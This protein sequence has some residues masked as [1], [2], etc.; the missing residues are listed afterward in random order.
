MNSRK[1]CII[2][3]VS[4]KN[5]INK[6]I[7][8]LNIPDGYELEKRYIVNKKN[9]AKAYNEMMRVTDAKYKIYLE[10]GASINNN[11]VL[12]D[13]LNIFSVNHKIGI[14]GVVGAVTIPTSGIW[15]E[16][17]HKYGKYYDMPESNKNVVEYNNIEKEYKTAK[18][19]DGM[20]IAT[21]YEIEWREDL[22]EDI[23]FYNVSQCI[24]FTR[25]GFEIAIPK[26]NKPWCIKSGINCISQEKY[27][28]YN[29]IFLDEYSKD[30]FPMVSILMPT[31]NRSAYFEKAL[32]SALNQTYR[33]IE[34]IVCDD[35][36]N[37]DTKN[38][39][40]KYLIKNNKIK[41]YFNFKLDRFNN[42]K[43][44]FEKASGEFINCLFDDDIYHQEKVGKMMNYFI[45]Y[46]DIAL[47]T[48][49]RKV[50]DSEG[51][52]LPDIKATEKLFDKDTILDGN[53]LGKV[54]I[55]NQLNLIGETTT[56]LHK[57]DEIEIPELFLGKSYKC[58]ADVARWIKIINNRRCVY[59]SEPL[60]YFRI[61]EGQH[62]QELLT[63]LY[64]I[65]DWINLARGCY[66]NNMFIENEDEYKITIKSWLMLTI[67][68]ITMLNL[69]QLNN[70]S[71]IYIDEIY[72]N[73]DY[74][75]KKIL[76]N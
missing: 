14:I 70:E 31:H 65:I 39:I 71:K 40:Q 38:L 63:V 41:Y 37:E 29:E 46:K 43:M 10:H 15:Q 18:A 64:G 4:D 30:I 42:G 48:S 25:A 45:E 12:N 6:S 28:G 54:V 22:F 26:Q 55:M 53:I 76:I 36:D 17:I 27:I 5:Q 47:V 7:D 52:I 20:F 3:C 8:N 62:H 66:E 57:K 58:I 61:H 21:Q 44:L 35:S 33:N 51:N 73:I 34:I 67:N 32:L 23:Y 16:S 13:I 9:I 60:S 72:E 11:N 56:V 75:L 59:I 1:I 74:V 2:A 19:I 49:Y 69:K 50:I 24:E 68:T